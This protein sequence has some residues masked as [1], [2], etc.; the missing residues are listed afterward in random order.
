M[1]SEDGA[2]HGL[3]IQVGR[4]QVDIPRSLGFYGAV[5]AA[6]ACGVI[7]APLGAFIAVVPVVKMLGRW[8]LPWPLRFV[9]EV[10]DGAAQPVGGEAQGTVRLV[11]PGEDA[12][13]DV[14]TAEAARRGEAIKAAQRGRSRRGA[15]ASV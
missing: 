13:H 3:I 11:D 8:D 12:E 10:A 1:D 15:A 2:A 5:A 4:L 6:V 9:A 7:E 14:Q